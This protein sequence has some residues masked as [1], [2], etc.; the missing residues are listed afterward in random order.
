MRHRRRQYSARLRGRV[1]GEGRGRPLD[2]A[3]ITVDAVPATDTDA[4][5]RF[6]LS[7]RPGPHH[8]QI[9]LPGYDIIDRRVEVRQTPKK[10]HT[11]SCSVWRR[12]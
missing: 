9:Q 5:G 8:V 12:A 4:T 3:S 7:V 11:K 2:G 1:L 10:H 6:E